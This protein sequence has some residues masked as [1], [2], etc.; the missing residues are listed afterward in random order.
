MTLPKTDKRSART[1]ELFYQSLFWDYSEIKVGESYTYEELATKIKDIYEKSLPIKH[2]GLKGGRDIQFDAWKI[3]LDMEEVGEGHGRKYLILNKHD[4]TDDMKVE[5][6][7]DIIE[8]YLLSRDNKSGL[9]YNIVLFLLAYRGRLNRVAGEHILSME[10]S[11]SK[12]EVELGMVSRVFHKV[13]FNG[14]NI[15]TQSILGNI[16]KIAVDEVKKNIFFRAMEFLG[17]DPDISCKTKTKVLYVDI[18]QGTGTDISDAEAA[19]A[20]K[21]KYQNKVYHYE[22]GYAK[23]ELLE[24]IK[25]VEDRV[26][27]EMGYDSLRELVAAGQYSIYKER[28]NKK[29]FEIN[30]NGLFVPSACKKIGSWGDWGSETESEL[31]LSSSGNE[32]KNKTAPQYRILN[33]WQVHE[34]SINKEELVKR[35]R[36]IAEIRNEDEARSTKIC[37][38]DRDLIADYLTGFKKELN[39]YVEM[40]VAPKV[41]LADFDFTSS[42]GEKLAEELSWISY[43]SRYAQ[44]RNYSPEEWEGFLFGSKEKDKEEGGIIEKD[45]VKFIFDAD[46]VISGMIDDSYNRINFITGQINKDAPDDAAIFSTLE[47]LAA[48]IISENKSL[49]EI[50]DRYSRKMGELITSIILSKQGEI[51]EKGFDLDAMNE[52]IRELMQTEF[53]PRKDALK[54]A[55]KIIAMEK[56]RKS[57]KI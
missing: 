46:G 39:E 48:Q 37:L 27:V 31:I 8:E 29:V 6:G 18:G 17:R 28:V 20:H 40:R 2:G 42:E 38:Y 10:F 49:A 56:E 35:I 5:I 52:K 55:R 30:A 54:I 41:D 34:I 7:E 33:Y 3:T 32:G 26:L 1:V 50:K 43:F 47:K 14:D 57:K 16:L 4:Y 9:I 51:S 19:A 12:W 15:L 53:K 44:Y 25:V 23:D 11:K 21:I 45:G 13:L 22:S 24:M 36:R